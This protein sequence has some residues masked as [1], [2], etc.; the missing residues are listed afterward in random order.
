M[1]GFTGGKA[2]KEYN[3]RKEVDNLIMVLTEKW[4]GDYARKR[5]WRLAGRQ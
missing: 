3:V 1:V 5:K 4:S 2:Y